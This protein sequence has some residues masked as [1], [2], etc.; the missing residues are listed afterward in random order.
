MSTVAG[1]EVFGR[2]LLTV[3]GGKAGYKAGAIK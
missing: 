2:C 1:R 3:H